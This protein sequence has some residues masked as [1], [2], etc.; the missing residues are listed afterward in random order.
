[1]SKPNEHAERDALLAASCV[2]TLALNS[3]KAKHLK[4]PA[5]T[6]LR[7][8]LNLKLRSLEIPKS[9]HAALQQSANDATY[10]HPLPLCSTVANP[11]GAPAY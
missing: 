5:I 2:L 10:V 4:S 6:V 9:M 11:V 7:H 8:R 1:M 3:H